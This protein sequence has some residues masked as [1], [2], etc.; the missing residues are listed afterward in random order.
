MGEEAPSHSA[1]TP[2]AELPEPTGEVIDQTIS[3]RPEKNS[4]PPD[5]KPD[6]MS[7]A[8]QLTERKTEP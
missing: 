1:A 7:P 5:Y 8:D 2:T 4:I 3:T 6:T